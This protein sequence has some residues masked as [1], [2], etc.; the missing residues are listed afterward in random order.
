MIRFEE[1]PPDQRAVLSLLLRQRKRYDEVASALGI[2]P[3]AVHDRA[4]AALAVLAPRQAR[5]VDP[6]DRERIGEYLLGQQSAPLAAATKSYLAGSTA[7]REWA[8][9][10]AVELVKL[11]TESLPEIPSGAPPAQPTPPPP[12]QPAQPAA[13]DHDEVPADTAPTMPISRRG[14][15]ILLAAIIVIAAA[16]IAIVVSSGGG[17]SGNSGGNQAAS[18]ASTQSS[19]QTEAKGSGSSKAKLEKEAAL[20]PPQA[21]GTGEG[22][23]LIASEGTKR[24]LYL[25][26]KGL[27]ATEGFSY[28]VW[29][30]P[31]H[32]QP[33]PFGRTPSV[34]A[35][36]TLQAAEVLTSSPSA[37]SGIEV[38][39]ETVAHPTVPGTVVLKG[40]FRSA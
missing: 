10:L 40:D 23:A 11:A 37:L 22:A 12:A 17:G 9:A 28:V 27:A 31:H 4:H 35:K 30:I 16:V 8:R 34:G 1:L 38:T 36:G 6:A 7:A 15:A 18:R 39:R 33:F 2:E 14:G 13:L 25:A 32:G 21:G 29:L 3:S 26:A 5:L 19:S 24:A 20:K